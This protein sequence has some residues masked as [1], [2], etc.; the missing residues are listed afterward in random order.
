[1]RVMQFFFRFMKGIILKIREKT[2]DSQKY[3]ELV[4]K[5]DSLSSNFSLTRRV[6]F[7]KLQNIKK[8]SY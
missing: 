3:D 2:G 4:K 6:I 8:F 7:R 5:L 1:M